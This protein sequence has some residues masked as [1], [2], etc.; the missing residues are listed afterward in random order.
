MGPPPGPA[1]FHDH[2]LDLLVGDPLRRASGRA[3]ASDRSADLLRSIVSSCN[4]PH[5]LVCVATEANWHGVIV[6]LA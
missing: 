5:Y 6:A 1:L 4:R 2:R 3:R